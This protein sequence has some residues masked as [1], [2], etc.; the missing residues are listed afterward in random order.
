M[1]SIDSPSKG[2]ATWSNSTVPPLR[3]RRAPTPVGFR[4]SCRATATSSSTT[5]QTAPCGPAIPSGNSGADLVLT[6][7]GTLEVVAQGGTTLWAKP[8]V[9]LAGSQLGL[10]QSITSPNGQYR[11][12]LQGDGNLV[13]LDGSTT[14]WAAGTNP[15]GVSA[16]MQG[17]G[18]FVVYSA[19][20]SPLWASNTSGNSGADLVLTDN[21]TLEVVAQGGTTLW[22]KPNVLLAGSQLGLG[23]SIT[24]PNGQ[25]RL[26][27]QGDGNLVELDGSTTAWAAGTNP[28]GVSAVMQGDGNFVVYSASNSPLWASNTSGNS[29]AD[30]VLTDNGTL[31]VVA[32]GGTTLWAKPNVLLAGSQLGLG[33]SITSPNGQYR[34]ALQGDGNLVELDGSTTAW[35]AG[36]NPGGVSAVMQGDGNFVVYSASNSPLWASNTSGNPELTW[37]SPTTGPSR[38]W[39]R[40]ERRCGQRHRPGQSSPA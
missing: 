18:N 5:A 39:P 40:A 35:A 37:S 23:Q 33:Q 14:A 21:G 24:S 38:W 20:N 26:A 9:L 8:N 6:D 11:L 13:E 7:N 31:E 16:V 19:S 4:P 32:Q 25:Y 29:G 1:G 36:T 27:L 17:D 10:G 34:L 28:G 3:G 12:A 2:T 15:G 30:L 22:A